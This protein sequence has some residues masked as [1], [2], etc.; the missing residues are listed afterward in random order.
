MDSPAARLRGLAE[1]LPDI[2]GP[3]TEANKTPFKGLFKGGSSSRNSGVTHAGDTINITI[4]THAGPGA[5]DEIESRMRRFFEERDRER[6][7]ALHDGGLHP[8]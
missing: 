3:F 8:E 4:Q 1:R 5:I 6:R 2:P 7:Y